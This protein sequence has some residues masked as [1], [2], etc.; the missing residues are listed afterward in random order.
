M[1]RSLAAPVVVCTLAL[2]PALASAATPLGADTPQAVV[3]RLAQGSQ[4]RDF[5]EVVACLD[6]DTRTEFATGMLMGATM[7]V[8]FMG[9]GSD[10]AEGMAQGMSEAAGAPSKDAQAQSAKAKAE[11]KAKVDKAKAGLSAVFKRHGL[12]D[13]TDDKAPAPKEDLKTVLA[14][15]DQPA[16]VADLMAFMD[17]IGDKQAKEASQSL[18]NPKNV[19]DYKIQGDR[20]TARSGSET[21]DF[22]KVEGRW[23]LKAPAKGKPDSK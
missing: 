15:A 7:M 17:T 14:R 6:P 23:F 21:I 13:L 8:G 4:A 12:P 22:V 20:A 16:L 1:V 5:R 3:D 9:M 18:P 19:T 11:T 10:M 2:S